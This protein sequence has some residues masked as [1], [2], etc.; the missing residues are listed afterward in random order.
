MRDCAR[1]ALE[2]SK[3]LL[4]N[5]GHCKSNLDKGLS[6][7]PSQQDASQNVAPQLV[8]ELGI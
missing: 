5:A 4:R 2:L 6:S 8:V 3:G 1:K 7:T